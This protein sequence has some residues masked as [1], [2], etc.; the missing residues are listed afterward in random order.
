[1]NISKKVP[2]IV[3]IVL[4]LVWTSWGYWSA[5]RIDERHADSYF[6]MNV[7]LKEDV[8]FFD[9]NKAIDA[10]MIGK[11]YDQDYLTDLPAGLEGEAV[12]YY[13]RRY[14][15]VD[16][17]EKDSFGFSA[18]FSKDKESCIVRVKTG[19]ESKLENHEISYKKI[20]NYQEVISAFNQKVKEAKAEWEMQALIRILI[21]I[22][23][24]VVFSV[25][26]KLICNVANEFEIHQAVFGIITIAYVLVQLFVM[27]CLKLLL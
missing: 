2:V 11:T 26:F 7:T 3:S 22:A 24:A 19:P 17:P 9:V 5:E 15:N 10:A 16:D 8:S 12:I 4:V 14:I 25:A 21:G 20:D 6:R 13:S 23:A 18:S 27:F 1:M